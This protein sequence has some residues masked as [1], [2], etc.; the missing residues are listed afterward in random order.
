VAV[1]QTAQRMLLLEDST[2]AAAQNL[3]IS[4]ALA[5]GMLKTIVDAEENLGPLRELLE[6]LTLATRTLQTVF[7]KNMAILFA[8]SAFM[9][10]SVMSISCCL[11]PRSGYY[12]TVVY[13][14]LMWGYVPIPVHS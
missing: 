2:L 6:S 5:E 12:L 8:V 3:E 1:K 11:G 9:A 4:S 14:K 13:C 10:T 7:S